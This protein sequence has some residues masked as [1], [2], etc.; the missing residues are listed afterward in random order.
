MMSLGWEVFV[1]EFAK[2]AMLKFIQGMFWSILQPHYVIKALNIQ[3]P[4][5]ND[6]LKYVPVNVF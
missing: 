3:E 2:S 5:K 4:D 6:M 1:T